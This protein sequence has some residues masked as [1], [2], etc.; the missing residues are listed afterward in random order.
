MPVLTSFSLP[1]SPAALSLSP[2]KPFF[3]AFLSS[4]DPQTNQPWCPD[5]RAALPVLDDAFSANSSPD[6]AYV[7]VGQRPE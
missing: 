6:A 3:I 1:G 2:G 5:V 7:E 4:N